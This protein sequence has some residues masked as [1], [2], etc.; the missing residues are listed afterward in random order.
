MKKTTDFGNGIVVGILIM[1]ITVILFIMASCEKDN[2]KPSIGEVCAKC[3][4]PISGYVAPDFCASP[5]E[6][7]V[8]VRELRKM[9]WICTVN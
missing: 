3:T 2:T 8:Y 1:G 6:V 7:T 9:N 5:V 4:E